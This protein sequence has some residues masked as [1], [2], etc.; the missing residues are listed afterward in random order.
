MRGGQLACSEWRAEI[1]DDN[2][3]G[4]DSSATRNSTPKEITAILKLLRQAIDLSGQNG[5][6]T[7]V[8][9][10]KMAEA[11]AMDAASSADRPSK[12]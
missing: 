7:L 6:K 8:Y 11:E 3:G 2:K 12:D 4:A 1:S 5:F 10:L 9:L